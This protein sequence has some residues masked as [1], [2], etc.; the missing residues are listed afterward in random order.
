MLS[1]IICS[2]SP[3]FLARVSE[4]IE[5]TVGCEY[6]LIVHDN[7]DTN[8]GICKVYNFCAEKAKYPYLCFAHEDIFIAKEGWGYDLVDYLEK[9]PNVGLIGVAGLSFISERVKPFHPV[10]SMFL[11]VR[12]IDKKTQAFFHGWQPPSKKEKFKVGVVDGQFLLTRKTVWSDNRFDENNFDGFHLYD[13]DFSMQINQKYIIIATTEIDIT[14]YSFG[15]Y[16]K[17]YDKYYRLFIDKWKSRLPLVLF[18]ENT[19]SMDYLETFTHALLIALKYRDIRSFKTYWH[20]LNQYVQPSY[21]PLVFRVLI[22]APYIL[23][24][25][26]RLKN[27]EKK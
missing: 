23:F 11:N 26:R 8:Y 27:Y 14:H 6:E 12:Q 2:I 9:N 21:I 25:S 1:I 7:R 22:S 16:D 4:N 15:N 3:E 19:S 24:F 18:P 13:F 10:K 5:N 20:L 17:V